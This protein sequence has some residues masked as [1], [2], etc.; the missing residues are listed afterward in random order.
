[1]YVLELQGCFDLL[2]AGAVRLDRAWT[3]VTML[4]QQ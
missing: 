1:M 4:V 2:G 3:I